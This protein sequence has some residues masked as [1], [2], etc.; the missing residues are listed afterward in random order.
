MT[1]SLP[2]NVTYPFPSNEYYI[3]TF[4]SNECYAVAT[5]IPFFDLPREII[6]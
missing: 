6:H 5:I 4:P 3:Y 2:M 1:P